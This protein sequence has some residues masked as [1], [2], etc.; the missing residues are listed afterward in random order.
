[1]IK[2][3]WLILH[4]MNYQIAIKLQDVYYVQRR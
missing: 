1:V 2:Y 4:Q 3:A